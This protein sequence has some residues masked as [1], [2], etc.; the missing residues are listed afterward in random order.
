MQGGERKREGRGGWA[1]V[2]VAWQNADLTLSTTSGPP[3]L[4]AQLEFCY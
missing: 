1:E 3:C 4:D 2:D